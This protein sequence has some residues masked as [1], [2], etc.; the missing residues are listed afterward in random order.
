LR[1]ILREKESPLPG[2]TQ[3]HSGRVPLFGRKEKKGMEHG[4]PGRA[5]VAGK[6]ISRG[7]PGEGLHVASGHQGTGPFL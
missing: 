7:E 2:K 4:I 5:R 1:Q 6:G 3:R